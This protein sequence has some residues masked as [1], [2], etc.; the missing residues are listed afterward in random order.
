MVREWLGTPDL[1]RYFHHL[2]VIWL[3]STSD[4]GVMAVYN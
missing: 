4:V 2:G 3:K 1:K